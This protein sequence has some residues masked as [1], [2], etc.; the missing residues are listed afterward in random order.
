MTMLKGYVMPSPGAS[1][2][3]YGSFA[4]FAASPATHPYWQ[5]QGIANT[6]PAL[7]GFGAMLTGP[8]FYTDRK[9]RRVYTYQHSGSKGVHGY[10]DDAPPAMDLMSPL[11][12]VLGAILGR[13]VLG[14]TRG[15]L[16]GAGL[17]YFFRDKF[18]RFAA[19]G[20]MMGPRSSA[21]AP[22]LP[23]VGTAEYYAAGGTTQAELPDSMAT[24]ADAAGTPPSSS[25]PFVI[26]ALIGLKFLL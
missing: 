1:D 18:P 8:D 6:I 7:N 19:Y 23:E 21:T 3:E 25:T 11:P 13:V 20:F 9:G 14:N 22:V 10:G 2:G 26:A 12:L 15:A 4:G 16:I 5:G 17:G 24:H